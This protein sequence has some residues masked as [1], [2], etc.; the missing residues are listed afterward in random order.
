MRLRR[1]CGCPILILLVVDAVF[2]IG[3]VLSLISGPS[4]Q[5]TQATTWTLV[6]SLIVTG[7]NLIACAILAIA[8]LRGQALGQSAAEQDS[9][10]EGIDLEKEQDDD[11]V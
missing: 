11:G 4:D 10:E 9:S 6:L 7:G 1:G 2:F 5:P 3:S 8:A